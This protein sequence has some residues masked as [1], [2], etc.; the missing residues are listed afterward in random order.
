MCG[1]AGI[2][3]Y[4]PQQLERWRIENMVEAMRHRGPDANGFFEDGNI[5]LGHRRLSIID[6]SD[7]ADQPMLSDDSRY[8]IVF[9]GEIYNF[10]SLK[11][12]LP[13]YPF[14]TQSDTEVILAA[15][16]TWKKDFVHYL[17][18]M[19]SLAIW[20]R[21]EEELILVRDRLGVKPLY[22]YV[23]DKCLIFASEIRSILRSG[24]VSPRLNTPAVKEF[25]AFQSIGFPLSIIEDIHQLDAGTMLNV[26]NGRIYKHKYWKPIP[27]K[28]NFDFDLN[29]K[30]RMRSE[31]RKRLCN[32]VEERLISDVPIGAF[33]SGGI[34]SS[35]IVGLMAEVSGQAPQ[36][37]TVGM[38]E[39]SFDESYYASLVARRFGAVHHP[40]LLKPQSL[41]D[42]LPHALDM[43]DTPSG[44]GINSYIISKAVKKAGLTVA[45]SGVGGDE[46]FAGY[47]LFRRYMRFRKFDLAWNNTGWLRKQLAHV[48]NGHSTTGKMERIVHFVKSPDS[49]IEFFYPECRRILTPHLLNKLT[50][51]ENSY[52][53]LVGFQLQQHRKELESL[54][55][56]SQVTVADLLGYTQNTLLKDIDQMSMAVSLEV[57]EPF[58]DH[59]LVELMLVAPDTHKGHSYPKSLL[60]ESLGNIIPKEIVNR[61][62]QGFVFPWSMW[63]KRELQ[64]FCA[65]YLKKIGERPFI[66]SN[67]LN[68]YWKRFLEGDTSVRWM[69]IWLFV[70]LEYWLEKNGV[71]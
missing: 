2:L 44:D 52:E 65:Y 41:L 66:K 46:L 42:E 7:A 58:F 38:E 26:K 54:P 32:A 13:D 70:V 18:G 6:L 5:Q 9:N 25:L 30:Q 61:P 11:A 15:Y 16:T 3:Y 57:R 1:I 36:T 45:L 28:N 31:I 19:F 4:K 37:F 47:P 63:M 71:N 12:M 50:N 27:D 59:E 67:E 29:D 39:A 23:N 62:K 17:K 40:I 55:L 34:D 68:K 33:L 24:L 48:L 20:D 51:F 64:S 22:L 49:T 43:M 10:R 8:V 53:S 35:A 14:K 60:V 69:E 21:K 56:L